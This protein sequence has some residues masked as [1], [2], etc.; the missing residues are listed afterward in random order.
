MR[1]YEVN[2][3]S[4]GK[5]ITVEMEDEDKRRN[6]DGYFQIECS[7]CNRKCWAKIFENMA[8]YPFMLEKPKEEA[9]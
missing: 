7:H 9:P 4:C 5:K 1:E 3:P 8:V 2:C 6:G